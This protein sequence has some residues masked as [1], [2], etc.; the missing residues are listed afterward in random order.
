MA[1]SIKKLS[2]P[3]STSRP[4][5]SVL[6]QRVII[7]LIKQRPQ[8][9]SQNRQASRCAPFPTEKKKGIAKQVLGYSNQ[10]ATW[11]MPLRYLGLI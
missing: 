10:A 6:N 3:A 5:G 2:V 1:W 8:D 7:L 11:P 4:G 9:Q